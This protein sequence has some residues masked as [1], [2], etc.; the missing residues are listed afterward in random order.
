MSRV[1]SYPY[2]SRIKHLA[3]LLPQNTFPTDTVSVPG[4]FR[5]LVTQ[6]GAIYDTGDAQTRRSAARII[7][8]R[9]QDGRRPDT[10]EATQPSGSSRASTP[11]APDSPRTPMGSPSRVDIELP[12]YTTALKEYSDCSDS[13]VE[14]KG[15][16][17]SVSPLCWKMTA[18]VDEVEFSATAGNKKLAKHLAS[19]QA[20]ESLAVEV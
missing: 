10:S 9:V 20:C 3:A 12:R 17:I 15:E 14:W 7:V 18:V 6:L 1:T 13:S 16:Q 4:D 11:R 5:T 19:Q 8:H 2:L